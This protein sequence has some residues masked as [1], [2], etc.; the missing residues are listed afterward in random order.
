M[1]V[2]GQ[3]LSRNRKVPS[4]RGGGA[5]QPA[6]QSQAHPDD[7]RDD[8]FSESQMLYSTA[9]QSASGRAGLGLG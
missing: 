2:S 1:T 8:V 5:K 3:E 6:S 9:G 7:H 4:E